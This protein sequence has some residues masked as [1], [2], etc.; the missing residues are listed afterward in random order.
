MRMTTQQRVRLQICK[1][2]RN[3]QKDLETD[4]DRID[5]VKT[6]CLVTGGVGYIGAHIVELSIEKLISVSTLDD[7]STGFIDRIPT[8]IPN[9]K[10]SLQDAAG[11]R[12]VFDS[13]PISSVIHLAAKKRVAESVE[14]PDYYRQE[15]VVGFQNLLEVMLEY[16]VK[17]LLFSSSAA[18][19]GQP[20]KPICSLIAESD[21]CNPINPYGETKLEGERLAHAYAAKHDANVIAL[22][23]FNVA[24][25]GRNNL[26]DRFTYNL[27]PIVFEAIDREEQPIVFGNDYET[28][29][30]T[31]I[32]D[33]IHAQDLADA[34][35]AALDL[36]DKSSPGFDVI[37][38]GT[39]VGA[40]VLEVIDMISEVTGRVIHPKFVE[41]RQ[42]DPAALVADVRKAKEVLGW[43]S[44]YDLRDI[45][46]SAWEAWQF[47]KSRP[48]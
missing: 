26:G 36:I 6:A 32:R 20:D 8:G 30:G 9:F 17:N 33:Y 4:S 18:V 24:G 41:R 15:N 14:R 40:S 23:Y 1:P 45:V 37:N 47:D 10:I 12:Q 11:L 29:D 22:R 3:P 13:A 35:I 7:L 31:C 19:Y 48:T 42:G 34:H 21:R 25:A 16:K 38:I 44:K 43:E 39:G 46:T 5:N 28:P 2:G 27:I